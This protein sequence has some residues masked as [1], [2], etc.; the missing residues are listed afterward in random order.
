M[1]TVPVACARGLY[2]H[3]VLSKS[4]KQWQKEN[5]SAIQPFGAEAFPHKGHRTMFV[6]LLELD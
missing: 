5:A 4:S 2:Y 6:M 1:L 3:A